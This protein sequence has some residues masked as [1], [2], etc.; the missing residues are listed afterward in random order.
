[1]C[2]RVDISQCRVI[3]DH[4]S[5]L[6]AHRFNRTKFPCLLK[7]FVI[8][9]ELYLTPVDTAALAGITY[10]TIDRSVGLNVDAALNLLKTHAAKIDTIKVISWIGTFDILFPFQNVKVL[11]N[12]HFLFQ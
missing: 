4:L 1:M 2:Q 12:G 5:V 11:L 8:L 10:S 9:L 7:V 3:S 6:H